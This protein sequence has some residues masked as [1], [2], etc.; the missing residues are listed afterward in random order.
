V[1]AL[2]S[3]ASVVRYSRFCASHTDLGKGEGVQQRWREWLEA[4]PSNSVLMPCS[5][6]ALEL[7]AR[8]R[9]RLVE[10]GF[11]PVEADDAVAL[12]MLDKAR[13]YS[14]ARRIGVPTPRTFS[15]SLENLEAEGRDI[16]YPCAV[17]PLHSHVFQRLETYQKV[18]LA[19]DV[20]ELREIL[21]HTAELGLETMVTEIV[22][23][24]DDQL[25]GFLSYLDL[26]G[27][28]VFE[29][30]VRKLRQQPI[31]F[32]IGCYRAND[33]DSDVAELGR[34]FLSG[35]GVRGLAQVEFKRDARDGTLK[36][37]EC[38]HRL[39]AATELVR[40]SGAE[41]PLLVYHRA[42]GRKGPPMRPRQGGVRL[43]DPLPDVR[44]LGSYRR[45]GELTTRAWVGSLLHRQR[46]P[47]FTWSDPLASLISAK[48]FI[49][50]RVR[51][52]SASPK[53]R[54]GIILAGDA[55]GAL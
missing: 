17:K 12:T 38:N 10:L 34:R 49:A 9:P 23:G 55:V 13:T 46:F 39:T 52:A 2:T 20:G 54:A 41:T 26:D 3:K 30:T 53:A 15:G 47:V 14:L 25:F 44:S 1:H 40:S 7:I 28:P 6:D 24:G 4:N 36:L 37:I 19:H 5:D 29:M 27:E 31:H 35:A 32:G 45:S 21:A 48:L 43:W 33:W 51:G 8:N 42:L 22:P 18:M 16:P 11:R 50:H